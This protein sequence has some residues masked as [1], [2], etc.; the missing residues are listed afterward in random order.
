MVLWLVVA[1]SRALWMAGV[2]LQWGL[3][4]P[5]P[6]GYQPLSDKDAGV[7]LGQYVGKEKISAGFESYEKARTW[8]QSHIPATNK[9]TLIC[10][11]GGRWRVIDASDGTEGSFLR[12]I[13]DHH[14][15]G[16]MNA[17]IREGGCIS[18]DGFCNRFQLWRCRIDTWIKM[19]PSS[20][21]IMGMKNSSCW[22]NT[23]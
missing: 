19:G 23:L 10:L 1:E 9:Y 6:E 14:N 11:R 17:C 21:Q 18:V 22:R 16:E 8:A 7:N 12:F 5:W 13:N 4:C 20:L 2:P 3:M 15:L